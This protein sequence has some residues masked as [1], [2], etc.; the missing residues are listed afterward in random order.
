MP[1]WVINYPVHPA[2]L[3]ATCQ[4]LSHLYCDYS[5]NICSS[6]AV[7]ELQV[8]FFPQCQWKAVMLAGLGVRKQAWRSLSTPP[9]KAI[10]QT[11]AVDGLVGK[12][13]DNRWSKC[14]VVK[15]GEENGIS[16]TLL[17]ARGNSE[18]LLTSPERQHIFSLPCGLTSGVRVS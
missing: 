15:Q 12:Q 6:S 14:I 7:P 2:F 4:A 3:P 18:V 8:V 17:C 16:F 9:G 1:C 5:F 13:V 11:A 10:A